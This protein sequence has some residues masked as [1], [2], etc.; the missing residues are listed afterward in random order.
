MFYNDK[1]KYCVEDIKE[2]A[3]YV[4]L[5][6]KEELSKGIEPYN[7]TLPDNKNLCISEERIKHLKHFLNLL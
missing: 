1:N 2:K 5:D 4:A 3:C 7:Y 6:Y